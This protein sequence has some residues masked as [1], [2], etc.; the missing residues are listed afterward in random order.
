MPRYLQLSFEGGVSRADYGGPQNALSLAEDV[1]VSGG[2]V[3]VRNADLPLT[4]PMEGCDSMFISSHGLLVSRGDTVYLSVVSGGS[5]FYYPV[6]KCSLDT[7]FTFVERGADSNGA[8]IVY[9]S[10][11]RVT[12]SPKTYPSSA[13]DALWDSG[14]SVRWR[15]ACYYGDGYYAG[16]VQRSGQATVYR[17]DVAVSVDNQD[18]P[19]IGPGWSVFVTDATNIWQRGRVVAASRQ[20]YSGKLRLYCLFPSPPYP[21]SKDVRFSLSNVSPLGCPAL[22][23]PPSLSGIAGDMYGVTVS[24]YA[25]YA[26][27]TLM[28]QGSV[29]EE[30][31][32]LTIPET[33]T[34]GVRLTFDEGILEPYVSCDFYKLEI[35]RQSSDAPLP[36]LIGSVSIVGDVQLDSTGCWGVIGNPV[37]DDTGQAGSG[38]IESD[39]EYRGSYPAVCKLR[40]YNGRLIGHDQLRRNRVW[41]SSLGLGNACEYWPD[42]VATYGVFDIGTKFAGGSIQIG[43]TSTVLG[44]VPEEG[45]FSSSGKTG[46]SL[47]IIK[48]NRAYRLY[49]NSWD[50]I[51]VAE[52]F[53]VDCVSGRTLVNADGI[54]VWL[55]SRHIHALPQGA[56]SVTSLTSSILPSGLPVNRLES[57]GWNYYAA[58]YRGVYYVSGPWVSDR[59]SVTYVFDLSS[60]TMTE[61]SSEWSS[62]MKLCVPGAVPDYPQAAAVV[63]GDG[64]VKLFQ[65][66][67]YPHTSYNIRTNVLLL[68]NAPNEVIAKK[69]IMKVMLTY[70]NTTGVQQTCHV[71]LRPVGDEAAKAW[72][73]ALPVTRQAGQVVLDVEAFNTAADDRPASHAFTIS[74]AGSVIEPQGGFPAIAKLGFHNMVVV[75]EVI[76]KEPS[77]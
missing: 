48:R 9:I 72:P 29:T 36:E 43:D 27:D 69:R 74:I 28:V 14:L 50:D 23:A 58:Y 25:R 51:S 15:G 62:G 3:F 39:A 10:P 71:M 47:F 41:L 52:L 12:V 31:A 63:F 35:F 73:V 77:V 8:P 46:A 22:N 33:Q 70:T 19:V 57:Q 44:F 61:L 2:S 6:W 32:S 60:N 40:E 5:R 37:F 24:Y 20:K 54:L 53:E 17:L 64:D 49:G 59:P 13:S 75:Y 56:N 16:A 30:S 11:V 68:A 34:G 42:D 55:G 26:S 4:P 7:P 18:A 66:A 21:V 76:Q 38:V 1:V 67:E 65:A 45:A